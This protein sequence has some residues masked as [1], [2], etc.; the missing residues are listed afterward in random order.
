[1]SASNQNYRRGM[2]L[3]EMLIATAVSLILMAAVAQVFAAFSGAMSNGRS[4]L[5]TDSRLRNVARRLRDDLNGATTQMLPPR[6]PD[7]GEGYFEIIEGP[8]NDL[9]S[10][11][12]EDLNAD[13]TFQA[14]AEE[15]GDGTGTNRLN[16][17]AN[18][19][20]DVPALKVSTDL[21]GDI[22]DVLLFTTRS[23]TTPFVGRSP[24]GTFESQTAE[25]AWF[26]RPT[27]NISNPQTYTL[28]RKQVLVMGYVG[29]APFS[30]NNQMNFPGTWSGYFGQPCDI[31]ARRERD[32]GAVFDRLVPNTL[33]DLTRREN[34]FLHNPSGDT[35]GDTFPYAFASD[36][37][38]NANNVLNPGTPGDDINN[39]GILDFDHLS[40]LA[41]NG[42]VFDGTARRGEDIVLTN[43]LGFDV[44][45][46]DPAA[47]IRLAS[48]TAVVP[49]DDFNLPYFTTAANGTGAYVDLGHNV[50]YNN[51]L[52][53]IPLF[54]GF[55]NTL[56]GLEGS[57]T[58]RRTYCTWS[59]HYEANGIDEDGIDG[60]D[61]GTDGLDSSTPLNSLVDESS[62][63]ETSPPYPYPLRGVEVRIRVYEP[64]SRQ[65]R[66]VTV[67]HTFVPH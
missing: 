3:I 60:T 36:I 5:E 13:G 15:T 56:S 66:Q 63:Q 47:P 1:M 20:L 11:T 9:F 18:G 35:T 49:G 7:Q 62:E 12:S 52:S 31:S 29:S 28:Y 26:V 65:A 6:T 32:S 16:A 19:L 22:D 34:R 42:L 39:N 54:S 10:Y 57:A 27:P 23:K 64:K 38:F 46:F 37:D 40:S 44:R 17:N 45:V 50:R 14:G 30:T 59:T 51:I 61:Q 58:S 25:V 41:P 21:S 53:A 55:G 2:T 48:S 43:V 24:T 33:S 4:I 67:R 8:I